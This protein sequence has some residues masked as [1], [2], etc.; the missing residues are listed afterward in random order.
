MIMFVCLFLFEIIAGIL[1]TL[2]VI[3]FGPK[4][5]VPVWMKRAALW[6]ALLVLCYG[7]MGA[8]L[9]YFGPSIHVQTRVVL[10]R[11]RYGMGGVFTGMFI[12]LLM[13]R[14]SRGTAGGEGSDLD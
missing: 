6:I 4:I 13:A 7:V 9:Y 10:S 14:F 12:A 3:V 5:E 1:L 2:M 11:C 8:V